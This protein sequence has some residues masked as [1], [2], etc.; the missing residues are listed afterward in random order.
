MPHARPCRALRTAAVVPLAAAF[1]LSLGG[2][3]V[4][5]PGGPF[6]HGS[7]V[8][9]DGNAAV[10]SHVTY[11]GAQWWKRNSLSGGT[12]P[13]AF[14]GFA[15]VTASPPACGGTWTTRPGNSSAPP[16]AVPGE[17]PVIVSS[18]VTKRGPVI[19]GD[20]TKIVLVATDPGY[21]PAPG[22]VGRGTV[23]GVL[24]GGGGEPPPTDQ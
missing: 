18:R 4:A 23:T 3:A 11:W 10:G 9:G 24:C 6:D 22:H 13:A 14:K 7:F 1:V 17:M 19:S 8:I 21:G 16:G 15:A 5:R 12:A 2:S 20:I